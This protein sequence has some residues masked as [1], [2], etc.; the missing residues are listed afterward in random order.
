[1]GKKANGL[2]VAKRLKLRRKQNR[3]I[4]SRI[5]KLRSDPLEGSSQ[6]RGI[7]LEKFELEAKQP[8]SAMR[9]CVRV[10]LSKNGKQVSAF[11]PG[12]GAIKLI[13]E[14]DEV[15]LEGMGGK[16]GGAKGDLSGIRLQVMKVNDQ[17]LDALLKGKI[18]KARR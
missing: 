9:K 14:H 6:A 11:A 3:R 15:I 17:S 12:D 18:E 5:Q 10:Q 2:N 1:M 7:V 4:R 8:N 16:Q 13:E